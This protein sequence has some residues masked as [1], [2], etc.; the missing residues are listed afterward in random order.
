MLVGWRCWLQK[1]VSWNLVGRKNA[2]N[3]A[4]DCTIGNCIFPL[5]SFTTGP[6]LVAFLFP[7]RHMHHWQGTRAMSYSWEPLRSGNHPPASTICIWIC[8]IL[9]RL[10]ERSCWCKTE[11]QEILMNMDSRFTPKFQTSRTA[12]RSRWLVIYTFVFSLRAYPQRQIASTLGL[13][14]GAYLEPK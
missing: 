7:F 10:C 5:A 8:E 1:F 2:R 3:L 9:D 12:Q 6:W 14:P 11:T 13:S 4:F